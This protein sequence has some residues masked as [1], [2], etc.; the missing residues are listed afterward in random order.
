MVGA[1]LL[2]TELV[3]PLEQP[4][5]RGGRVEAVKRRL[6]VCR[7]DGLERDEQI[8][9]NV[10]MDLPCDPTLVMALPLTDGMLD[11]LLLRIDLAVAA[12]QRA[13]KPIPHTPSPP[14]PYRRR[15]GCSRAAC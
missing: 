5:A 11:E 4:L 14:A 10:R 15:C 7:E 13:C 6:H 3:A 8:A 1:R 12:A 2:F 9:Q